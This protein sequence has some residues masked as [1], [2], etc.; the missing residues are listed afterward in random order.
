MCSNGGRLRIGMKPNNGIGLRVSSRLGFGAGGDH[1][2][3]NIGKWRLQWFLI[4]DYRIFFIPLWCDVTAKLSIRIISLYE[5]GD[6][7]KCLYKGVVVR[8]VALLF[9]YLYFVTKYIFFCWD[10]FSHQDQ[11][12]VSCAALRWTLLCAM[13]WI[14]IKDYIVIFCSRIIW[15]AL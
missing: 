11:D 2:H 4:A 10:A 14:S 6:G 7:F 3:N 13:R 9:K 1:D 8:F 5:G 12:Q 15:F